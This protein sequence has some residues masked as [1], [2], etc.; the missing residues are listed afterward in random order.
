[1][2]PF[3]VCVGTVTPETIDFRA[4]ATTPDDLVRIEDVIGL[5]WNASAPGTRWS[6]AGRERNRSRR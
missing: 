6:S 5:T 3:G 1:M 2:F 4:A